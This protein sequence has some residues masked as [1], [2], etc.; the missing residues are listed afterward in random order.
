M[1]RITVWR[2]RA[3]QSWHG[4]AS[5]ALC[6]SVTRDKLRLEVR[7]SKRKHWRLM[8]EHLPM[9]HKTLDVLLQLFASGL[10]RQRNPAHHASFFLSLLG[11][12]GHRA[13]PWC[14]ISAYWGKNKEHSPRSDFQVKIGLY[15]AP[16]SREESRLALIHS[17]SLFSP[18]PLSLH[19][20][21]IRPG[22][23]IKLIKQSVI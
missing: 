14:W 11:G 21:G 19:P 9:S 2:N 4:G 10:S 7:G 20:C 5:T 3:T 8:F 22:A 13:A 12:R 17:L 16:T 18:S 6:T 15:R 23:S 1:Y